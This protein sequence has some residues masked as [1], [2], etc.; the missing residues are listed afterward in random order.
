MQGSVGMPAAAGVDKGAH[1]GGVVEEPPPNKL[2]PAGS[3]ASHH[4]RR[5]FAERSDWTSLERGQTVWSDLTCQRRRLA[6][7]GSPS[8]LT[9]GTR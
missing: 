2:V 7:L 3:R 4:Q 1:V 8:G 6:K 9:L 5:E